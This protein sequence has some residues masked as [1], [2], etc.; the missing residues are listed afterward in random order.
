MFQPPTAEVPSTA[1]KAVSGSLTSFPL[2]NLKTG[3]AWHCMSQMDSLTLVVTGGCK[4]GAFTN[5]GLNSYFYN[6]V[7]KLWTDGPPIKEMRT[8]HGCSFITGGD[9]KPTAII[10]GGMND[11]KSKLKTVEIYN[12]TLDRWESLREVPE[13]MAS[14]QVK[15]S[16]KAK[17]VSQELLY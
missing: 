7:T 17:F 1:V 10:V 8:S 11:R 9:G 3:L 14:M 2:P 6:L 12:R 15:L 13:F 4:S 16:I 5:C